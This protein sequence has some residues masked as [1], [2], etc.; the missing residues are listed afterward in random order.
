MKRLLIEVPA[1]SANLGPGFDCLGLALNVVDRIEVELDPDSDEVTLTAQDAQLDSHDNL[2]CRSYREWGRVSGIPLPGARFKM[3]SQIPIA[4]GLG[5]S[6][7]SIVGG[8]AS[9]A[10][11]LKDPDTLNR[12][13]QIGSQLEGHP[14][15]VAAAAM[16][17]LT[18]AIM[19]GLHVRA[20]HVANHLSLGVALF[21]PNFSLNTDTARAA[22]PAHVPMGDAS[23]NLGRLAYLVTA[24][25]WGRWEEIGPAMQDRLHQ[26]YRK[27]LNPL[28]EELI[29]TAVATGAYGASLSGSGPTVI[30]LTP[31]DAV[32]DVASAMKRCAT[33]RGSEG[34]AIVTE[35]R[36]RGVTVRECK[37]GEK[38]A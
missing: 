7:S 29:G 28:L 32:K 2:V 16:G 15:N 21:V 19:D 24:L 37:E 4:R 5:S 18:T 26:P 9:A 3:E 34:S 31:H 20:L 13:I 25:I 30:A 14:D 1:T 36:E 17:G 23:F 22:L 12:I 33:E 8:L 27:S 10:G 6:A 11:S 38:P 35:V